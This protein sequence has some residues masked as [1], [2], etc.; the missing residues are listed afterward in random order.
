[1][2]TYSTPTL[3]VKGSV[4]ALTQG[5]FIGDTDPDGVTYT[6]GLDSADFAL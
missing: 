5:M 2:K 4:V 3:V 6:P 1:M